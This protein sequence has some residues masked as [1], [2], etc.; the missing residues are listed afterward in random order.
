MHSSDKIPKCAEKDCQCLGKG[1]LDKCSSRQVKSKHFGGP[2]FRISLKLSTALIATVHFGE[3]VITLAFR[4]SIS[5][6]YDLEGG[7]RMVS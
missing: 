4:V 2:D 3:I 1:S 5:Y 7:G 6:L